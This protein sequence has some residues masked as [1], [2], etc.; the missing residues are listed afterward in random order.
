MFIEFHDIWFSWSSGNP[1]GTVMYHSSKLFSAVLLNFLETKIASDLYCVWKKFT[2]G[3]NAGAGRMF[4]VVEYIPLLVVFSFSCASF[5]ILVLSSC[6]STLS[7]SSASLA[8]SLSEAWSLSS[9]ES[10]S[11]FSSVL[12]GVGAID[13]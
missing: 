8:S 6:S 10:F 9:S 2:G 1:A 4:S 5:V 3:M 7:S 13:N 12:A 11:A